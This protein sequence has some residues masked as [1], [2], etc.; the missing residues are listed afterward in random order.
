[1]GV[2]AGR[3]KPLPP[4]PDC[5]T[6]SVAG[7]GYGRNTG[8][9][10][11]VRKSLEGVLA[12]EVLAGVRNPSAASCPDGLPREPCG[13]IIVDRMRVFLQMRKDDLSSAL[14]YHDDEIRDK[15]TL[16]LGLWQAI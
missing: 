1:M 11:R 3:W 9:R 6:G 12:A 15:I 16:P 2:F 14:I 5:T 8:Q 7:T 13:P 10:I 4:G